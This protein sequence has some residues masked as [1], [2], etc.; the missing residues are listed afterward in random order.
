M[1]WNVSTL[2]YDGELDADIV[3][4]GTENAYIRAYFLSLKSEREA[5]EIPICR[6]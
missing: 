4:S 3:T 1:L 2:I 5:A 6:S